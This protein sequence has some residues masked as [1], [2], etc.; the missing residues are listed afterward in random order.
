M[1]L[2]KKIIALSCLWLVAA[3]TAQAQYVETQ[4]ADYYERT[5]TWEQKPQEYGFPRNMVLKQTA[6]DIYYKE[7]EASVPCYFHNWWHED[8]GK[9]RGDHD[10]KNGKRHIGSKS[11][12]MR[13]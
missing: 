8:A 1:P 12:D 2:I 13:S 9:Q 7:T 11:A 4:P 6:T 5:M 10:S 3:T